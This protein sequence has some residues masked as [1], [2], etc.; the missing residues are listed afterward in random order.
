MTP[1][2]VEIDY[3]AGPQAGGREPAPGELGLVQSFVNSHYDLEGDHGG[4]LLHSPRALAGWLSSRGLL[5]PGRPLARADL[6]RA[7]DVR[8]GLRAM[9]AANNGADWDADAVER[10][11]RA[12][13]RPG[14]VIQFHGDGPRFEPYERDFDGALGVLLGIVARAQLDNRWQRFKACPGDDCGW[15]FYD[16]SR[17]QASGWCSM[18]VCGSRSKARAYRERHNQRKGARR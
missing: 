3:S 5:D 12:M 18:S 8:E 6:R 10:L 14:I 7:L 4:E 15:A 17:N 16:Y 13:D 1:V 11:N 9:L 2:T